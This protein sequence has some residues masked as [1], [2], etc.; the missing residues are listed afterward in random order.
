LVRAVIAE[1]AGDVAEAWG[2]GSG[3]VCKWRKALRVRWTKGDHLR[4]SEGIKASDPARARKIAKAKRGIPRPRHVVEAL[5][6]AH[7]GKP[8]SKALRAKLSRV[9]KKL[10]IRPP[11]LN[12]AWSTR[13]D[14]IVRNKP[15]K[16]AAKVTGRTLAAVYARRSILGATWHWTPKLDQIVRTKSP[17]EAVKLTRKSLQA[18][19]TRRS[20]LGVKAG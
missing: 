5:R 16:E 10:G 1:S 13:E 7:L 9:R 4:R 17:S 14:R 3:L 11:W 8:L 18:I 15:P 6:R 12:P 20:Q 2:I 19:Y